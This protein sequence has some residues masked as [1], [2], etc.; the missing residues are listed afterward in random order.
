MVGGMVGGRFFVCL[1]LRCL[2]LLSEPGCTSTRGGGTRFDPSLRLRWWWTVIN[3]PSLARFGTFFR[4][5]CFSGCVWDGK[6]DLGKRKRFVVC[7]LWFGGKEEFFWAHAC[8][9]LATTREGYIR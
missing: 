2:A 1:A 8:G 4:F 3:P 5:R 6:G 9:I 7:G